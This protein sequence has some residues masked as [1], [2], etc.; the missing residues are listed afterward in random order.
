MAK[1]QTTP[2]A[3]KVGNLKELKDAAKKV[4]NFAEVY[5]VWVLDGEIGAGKTAFI[6]SIGQVIGLID[7]VNSPTFSI[8]NEYRDSSD[9]VYYHFDFYRTKNEEEARDMGAEE[10]FYSGNYCFIEWPSLI[11][12][13]LPDTY[14]SIDIQVIDQH[15]RLINCIKH[16]QNA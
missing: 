7:M 14:L 4:L 15:K 5:K 9:Q 3:I 2:L 12:S 1:T 6:Q 8:V 16:G 13:L 10:Y 11:R